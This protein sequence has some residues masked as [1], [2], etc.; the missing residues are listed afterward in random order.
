MTTIVYFISC[1]RVYGT[2]NCCEITTQLFKHMSLRHIYTMAGSV[3]TSVEY[4]HLGKS[5]LVVSN[6]CLG[7]M[8]FGKNETSYS[9]VSKHTYNHVLVKMFMCK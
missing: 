8:T 2:I 4:S 1:I 3:N 6:L 5:G 9:A 7:T